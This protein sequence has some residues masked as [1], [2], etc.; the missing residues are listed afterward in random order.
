[1]FVNDRI[2]SFKKRAFIAARVDAPVYPEVWAA[3]MTFP[4]IGLQYH[5]ADVPLYVRK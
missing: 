4:I 5:A 3:V 1:M 2:V